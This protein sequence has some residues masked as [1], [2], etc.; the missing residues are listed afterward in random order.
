MPKKK[1][2]DPGDPPAWYKIQDKD[3][4]LFERK[5][6]VSGVP[7]DVLENA[8]GRAGGCGPGQVKSTMN[9]STIPSR[10]VFFTT[11]LCPSLRSWVTS[12]V[13]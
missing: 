1:R 7:L 4:C 2:V 13:R 10:Q 12:F 5:I 9:S 6:P 3:E 8:G 11:I